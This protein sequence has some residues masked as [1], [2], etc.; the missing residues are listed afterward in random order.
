MGFKTD[1]VRVCDVAEI[2]GGQFSKKDCWTQIDYIDTGS[3]NKGRVESIKSLIPGEDKIPSR[4]RRKVKAGSIIY[5]MVRPNQRHYAYLDNPSETTL[6]STGFSVL[7]AQLDKVIPKYLYY[8]LIMDNAVAHFQSLAEQSVSTYPTLAVGDLAAYKIP[9]PPI[10]IQKRIVEICSSFDKK[11][12][13][14]DQ[15]NGY[16]AA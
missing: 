8:C 7:N 1:I 11:I 4:A 3:V 5:S 6:V 14:N 15:I 9:L 13:I 2:N 10:S 16:L 12:R